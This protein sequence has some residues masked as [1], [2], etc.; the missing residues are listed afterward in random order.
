MTDKL[1]KAGGGNPVNTWFAVS[2][3]AG[4]V[5]SKDTEMPPGVPKNFL[6]IRHAT[7]KY[8]SCR[9]GKR[10]FG[11]GLYKEVYDELVKNKDEW[12]SF[13]GHYKNQEHARDACICLG[14]LA[15]IYQQRQDFGA[16]EDVHAVMEFLLFFVKKHNDSTGKFDM[17]NFIIEREYLILQRRYHNN[18]ALENFKQCA[19]LMKDGVAFEERH[20]LK[21]EKYSFKVFWTTL[22]QRWNEMGLKP[23]VNPKRIDKSSDE[24]V[25]EIHL[26]KK[27]SREIYD[28]LTTN[29]ANGL[30][31][32]YGMPADQMNSAVAKYTLKLCDHCK[33]QEHVLGDFKQC[34]RCKNAV[35]CGRDCQLIAWRA[36]HKKVCL[37]KM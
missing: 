35:Y 15:E 24:I 33:K 1:T 32:H 6:L 10:Q 9:E 29:A 12:S 18:F 20:N 21:Q 19:R 34:N 23:K 28:G 7:D 30:A 37:K 13:F 27:M 14:E 4:S 25:I 31:A 11:E 17:L 2:T 22:A 3:H 8:T 16:C 26:Q 36:G 5:T